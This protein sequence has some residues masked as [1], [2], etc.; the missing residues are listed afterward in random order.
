MHTLV[1]TGPGGAGS[2]TLA[3]AAAVRAAAAG[4]STVL[5]TRQAPSVAGLADV[6]GLTVRT[7]DA[8]AEVE[9]FWAG[10]VAPA[11]ASFPQVALPPDEPVLTAE[12]RTR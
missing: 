4:R 11:A 3:A 5:L 8:G 2:S 6:P 10:A 9:R 12:A 7:V 1:L